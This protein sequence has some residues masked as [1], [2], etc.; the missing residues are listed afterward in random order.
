MDK[1]VHTHMPTDAHEDLDD[2]LDG[3]DDLV[4]ARFQKARR[5]LVIAGGGEIG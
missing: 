5:D 4:E 2:W 1:W 3:R